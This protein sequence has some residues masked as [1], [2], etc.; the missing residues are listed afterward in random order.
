MSI[1]VTSDSN[2][3]HAFFKTLVL[4][5]HIAL[6]YVLERLNIEDRQIQ[7]DLNN[8]LKEINLKPDNNAIHQN[9]EKLEKFAQSQSNK[10]PDGNYNIPI[11]C[12]QGIVRWAKQ[13]KL[14]KP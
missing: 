2:T 7:E 14:V 3:L 9:F 10:K 5:P 4:T 1:H 12:L 8:L 6:N 13:N 11:H